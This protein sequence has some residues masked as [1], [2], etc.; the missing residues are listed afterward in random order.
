[1]LSALSNNNTQSQQQQSQLSSSSSSP[2]ITPRTKNKD[3]KNSNSLPVMYRESK[4][5][6]YLKETLG[7][8]SK[9][10]FI[11]HVRSGNNYYQQA[12]TV[13]MYS[14]WATNIKNFVYL[15]KNDIGG[16]WNAPGENSEVE[17]FR[18]FFYIYS[19]YYY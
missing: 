4:I 7:G 5:T 14:T 1:V 19:Y 15:V 18:L 10:I 2:L 16:V 17:K 12:S 6:E 13:F 3:E 8:N 11:A 9:T